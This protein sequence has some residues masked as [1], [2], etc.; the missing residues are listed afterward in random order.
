MEDEETIKAQLV[1]LLETYYNGSFV[2]MARDYI[3]TT[4]MTK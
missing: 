2:Q 4:G 1:E 3:R